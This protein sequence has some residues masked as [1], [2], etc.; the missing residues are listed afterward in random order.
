MRRAVLIVC[1]YVW[2][3][4]GV[5]HWVQFPETYDPTPM[6]DFTF[7]KRSMCVVRAGY[8]DAHDENHTL[9]QDVLHVWAVPQQHLSIQ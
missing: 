7:R 5:G 2:N 4:L 9:C 6:S 3:E 8:A 1:P